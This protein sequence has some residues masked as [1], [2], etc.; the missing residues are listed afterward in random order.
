[1]ALLVMLYGVYLINGAGLIRVLPVYSRIGPRFFPYLVGI[2]A[3]VCGV[4]LLVGALRGFR[5]E[6]EGGE[7]V[8]LGVRDN[9]RP[10][11]VIAVALASG[12]LLMKPAGFVLASTVIFTGVALA[13]GSRRR[14]RD[15]AIGLLL[16]LCAYL[17]FTRLLSLTLP[18]G[19][20]PL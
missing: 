6:P 13:F 2:G 4:L 5:S 1:V 10:V 20:L 9:L 17:A 15:V 14:L 11:L 3:V 12:A 7:D 18:A 8:D 19:V 16:S